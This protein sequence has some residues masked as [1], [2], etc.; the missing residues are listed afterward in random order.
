MTKSCN[1]NI[2]ATELALVKEL[3]EDMGGKEPVR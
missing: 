3:E 1:G 2:P